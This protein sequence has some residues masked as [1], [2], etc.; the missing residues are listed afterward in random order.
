MYKIIN[1]IVGYFIYKIVFF[2]DTYIKS[3][4]FNLME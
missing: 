4:K 3:F 1:R 2:K